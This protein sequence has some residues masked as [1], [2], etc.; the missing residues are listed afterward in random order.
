MIVLLGGRYDISSPTISDKRSGFVLFCKCVLDLGLGAHLI[1]LCRMTSIA[2]RMI[3][4][5]AKKWK[6]QSEDLNLF[7]FQTY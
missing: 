2:A 7:V 4:D 6:N 3:F 5:V 1:L